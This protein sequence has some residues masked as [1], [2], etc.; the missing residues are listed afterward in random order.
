VASNCLEKESCYFN[1]EK[2]ESLKIGNPKKIG[3]PRFFLIQPKT[4]NIFGLVL[5]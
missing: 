5:F 1:L 4:A 2:L 3:I